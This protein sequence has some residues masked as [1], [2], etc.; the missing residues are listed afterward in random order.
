MIARRGAEY[1]ETLHYVNCNVCARVNIA[2]K[3]RAKNAEHA[4]SFSTVI[5]L[6]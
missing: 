6:A 3:A 5:I 2:L 1:R 4:K